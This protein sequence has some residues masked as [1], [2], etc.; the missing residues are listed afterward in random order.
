[1]DGLGWPRADG[2][3]SGEAVSKPTLTKDG[4]TNTQT[5]RQPDRHQSVHPS[6]NTIMYTCIH[7]CI[8]NCMLPDIHACMDMYIHTY[9]YACMI[10]H[11]HLRPTTTS[12]YMHE[13]IDAAWSFNPDEC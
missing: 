2:T 11:V 13:G 1:M 5:G 9:I 3:R 12:I 8:Q 4:Q 7:R 10:M 6:E